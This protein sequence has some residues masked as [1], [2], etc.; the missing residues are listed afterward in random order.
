MK[1]EGGVEIVRSSD[2]ERPPL[3]P[4]PETT[5]SPPPSQGGRGAPSCS[6][7]PYQSRANS[8]SVRTGRGGAQFFYTTVRC[9]ANKLSGSV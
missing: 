6:P 2:P 7:M 4:L 9:A 8:Q 3:V 1:A 5:L